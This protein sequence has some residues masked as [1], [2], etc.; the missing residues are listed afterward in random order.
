MTCALD[1]VACAAFAVGALVDQVDLYV[2][3][4]TGSTDG[5]AELIKELYADAIKQSRLVV[6]ELGLLP[7]YDLSIARNLALQRFRAAEIDYFIK[8]DADDVFHDAGAH[9]LVEVG[10]SLPGHIT[11]VSCS[12]SELY[13]WEAF[14]TREWLNAIRD[15]QPIFWE[16][17]F[18]PTHERVF[19]VAG[20]EAFGRWADEAAGRPAENIAYT[21]PVASMAL[22]EVLGAHYGWARP[23]KRKSEKALAWYGDPDADPRVDRLHLVDDW[24]RPTNLFRDHPEVFDRK[25][26]AVL[27]WLDGRH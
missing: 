19:A 2:F 6:E 15:A 7:E 11:H 5:T 25:V 20:A 10:R 13:Q 22:D 24:R 1:E 12:N 16:M 23:V 14:D 17:A 27:D 4:D 26:A 9:R 3:T 21:R 18:I 8:V